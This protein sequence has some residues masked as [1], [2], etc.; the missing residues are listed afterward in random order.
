MDVKMRI[1]RMRIQLLNA[2]CV[3]QSVRQRTQPTSMRRSLRW[4]NCPRDANV[5]AT[6]AAVL[7]EEAIA[8]TLRYRRNGSESGSMTTHRQQRRH[9]MY[10]TSC[11]DDEAIGIRE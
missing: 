5:R 11:L 8:M 9:S 1:K 4:R 3:A 7:A 6:D 10:P 2:Q